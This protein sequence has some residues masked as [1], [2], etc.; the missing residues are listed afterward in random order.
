MPNAK[1]PSSLPGVAHVD[2]SGGRAESMVGAESR[3]FGCEADAVAFPLGGIGTGNVSLGA[4]GE[5]RDWEIF[6]APAKGAALP[7]TF[8]AIRVQTASGNVV[9][10]VLQ[11]PMT[12]P[13]TRWHGYHPS[14]AAGL[15][16][17]ARAVFRGEYP[18]ARVDFEDPDLPVRVQLEAFTPLVPLDPADSGL[19]CA[20]LTY[21]VA[22]VSDG[23]VNITLVGSLANPVGGIEYDQFTNPRSGGPGGNVNEYLDERLFRGLHLRSTRIDPQD[24][25]Y[26]DLSLVTDHA[27]VT[28]KRAWL[29]GGRWDYLREFWDDLCD[30]GKLDDLGYDSP[31]SSAE[32]DTGS[33]GLCDQ[34]PPGSNREYRFL[35]TWYFPNRRASWRNRA[36]AAIVRN[37]YATRFTSSSD[38]ARYVFENRDRLEGATQDFHRAM[39]ASTLPHYVLDAVTANIVPLRSNT[40]FWL[41]TGGF[42]GWE[43]CSDTGGRC[44]GTCTHVWSYAYTLAYLFPSLERRMRWTEFVHETAENGYMAFRALSEFGESLML[45]GT[46]QAPLG[47]APEP[48]AAADGQLGSVLR[49]YREWLLSG[50]RP[51]LEQVWPGVKRAMEYAR[52][53]WDSDGD[54]IL[55]GPQHNTYDIELYGPNPLCTIYYLAALRASEELASVMGEPDAASKYR[56]ILVRGQ[57]NADHLMWNGHYYVQAVEDLNRFPYQIGTGCLSDQLLGQLHAHILGLGYLLP[58]AHVATALGSIFENNFRSGFRDHV[59]CQR[60]FVLNDE[61]GLVMCSWPSGGRPLY[62][63]VYSDEVWTGTEYQVAAHLIHEGLWHEGLAIVKSVRDRHDGIRRNPWDEVECGHHY[64]RSMASWAVLLALSGF[65]SDMG[66]RELRFE[67]RLEASTQTD[68]FT[69]FW[70]AGVG[71]GTYTQVRDPSSGTWEPRIDVLGG[72][73]MGVRVFACGRELEL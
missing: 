30:D 67:P 48:L 51:W 22:N 13:H 43:G 25:S 18:L 4:R 42:Y 46:D 19:P 64:A 73:M 20:L 21:R 39:F 65:H 47:S 66:R 11:A 31:S 53:H 28:V 32:T 26:G 33:L 56:Q 35:L 40:C 15:P 49:V 6:N 54:G 52:A 58:P 72:D 29:R 41:E 17:V 7:N 60:S 69:T 10:K 70:S 3:D 16:H 59:N 62:P 61:S 8:W 34:L 2:R 55:D 44:E 36:E 9:T 57:E 24:L 45:P 50:D 12:P 23:P 5:L 38:V 71:W 68:T 37:N 14:T 63:M 1:D 27:D